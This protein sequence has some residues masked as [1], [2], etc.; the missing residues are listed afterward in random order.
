MRYVDQHIIENA[1]LKIR[2]HLSKRGEETNF[3]ITDGLCRYW[4]NL[5]NKAVFDGIL[6]PPVYFEVRPFKIDLGWCKPLEDYNVSVGINEGIWMRKTFLC[7]LVHE[8][9]HT[10]EYQIHGK[11]THRKTF[12]EWEPKIRYRI[13]LP[14]SEYVDE[15]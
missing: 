2:T 11:M 15:D 1:R 10:Y 12:Y 6:S 7:V 8:M 14:L 13:G 9:V 3:A 4:W 5:L